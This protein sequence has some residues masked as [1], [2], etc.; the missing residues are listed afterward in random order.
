MMM[1]FTTEPSQ[2]FLRPDINNPQ[3]YTVSAVIVAAARSLRDLCATAA[4]IEPLLI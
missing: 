3:R 1:I 4:V 2:I